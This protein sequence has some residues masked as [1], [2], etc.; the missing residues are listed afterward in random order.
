VKVVIDRKRQ[1]LYF[2]RSPIPKSV[3]AY[4][5]TIVPRLG[6]IGIYAFRKAALMRFARLK[7]TPYEIAEHLEQLRLIE[8]G[9]KIK[10]SLTN[11]KNI[12]LNRKQDIPHIRRILQQER[13]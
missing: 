1:A 6:H 12:S 2:S 5:K 8:S 9:M 3:D 11:S 10:V 7:P 13:R 4:G